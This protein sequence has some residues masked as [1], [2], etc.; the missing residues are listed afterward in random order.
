V[1]K[2][3]Q[4][5]QDRIKQ[6]VDVSIGLLN[7][8]LEY[9]KIYD[10]YLPAGSSKEI[11]EYKT[12][13]I[14]TLL[15]FQSSMMFFDVVQNVNTLLNPVQNNPDKKEISFF[16]LFELLPSSSEN[17]QVSDIINDL[18][19]KLL[20]NK[21]DKIRNKFVGH[22]DLNIN[23]DPVILYLN[24]PNPDLVA[25]CREIIE[26]LNDVCLKHLDCIRNNEFEQL[27]KDSHKE[28]LDFIEKSLIRK[29]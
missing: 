1:S 28:Y 25:I 21:L 22:K 8:S 12:S 23:Y 14:P 9:K 29:E 4:E 10:K 13:P 15:R 2:E 27:Y 26:K 17:N 18:R 6:L 20:D 24:F 19:K 11:T 5:L 3:N 7:W 16:E